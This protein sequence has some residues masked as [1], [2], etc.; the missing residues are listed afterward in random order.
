MLKTKKKSV[1]LIAGTLILFI[2]FFSW[3]FI[4]KGRTAQVGSDPNTLPGIQTGPMPWPVE[5]ERLFSRLLVIGLP[6]LSEEGNALHIHQ[7]LDIFVNGTP[8][9]VPAGIGIN[10]T[11]RFISPIHTHDETGVIHIESDEVRDFTLGQ[12]FDIWGMRFTKD[13]VGGYCSKG[14][15]TLKVFLNG[16]PVAGDPRRLVLRSLQEI[17]VI[18]GPSDATKSAPSIYKFAPRL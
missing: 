4:S 16:R 7:H 9:V 3:G 6:A 10:E 18:Y 5:I 1:T 12:F 13:C 11:A 14:T 15:S 8:V 17:A 2:M